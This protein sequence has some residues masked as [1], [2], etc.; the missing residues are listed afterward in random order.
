MAIELLMGKQPQAHTQPQRQALI[1]CSR[2]SPEIASR[3]VPWRSC[4]RRCPVPLHSHNQ[5]FALDDESGWGGCMRARAHMQTLSAS[6]PYQPVDNGSSSSGMVADLIMNAASTTQQHIPVGPR[7][8]PC[9]GLVLLA[10]SST[11]RWPL[12]VGGRAPKKVDPRT[13]GGSVVL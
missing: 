5:V 8:G 13:R 6:R 2:T 11:Q 10:T 4:S 12:V 1:G 9:S 7:V 3:A